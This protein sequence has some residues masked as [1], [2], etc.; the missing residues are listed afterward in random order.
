MTDSTLFRIPPLAAIPGE[1]ASVE[2][3]EAY[4]RQRL[5]DMAWAYFDGGAGDEFTRRNNQLAFQDIALLNRA[6]VDLRGGHTKIELFGHTYEHPIFVA[7]VAYQ[8]LAHPDGELASTV[9]A[10]ALKT[11]MIVSTLASVSLEHIAQHAQYP[12]W[13][14]LYIQ[15]D[16]D[17]TKSLL[18]RAE[19]AG[20][21]AIVVTVD[22]PIN[23]VRNREQRAGFQLPPTIGAENLR[24]M[25]PLPAFAAMPGESSV[26]QSPMVQTAPTW[27]DFKWLAGQTR[28]PV[29]AKGILSAHDAQQAVDAG[30]AGVIVSNHGGRTLDTA[31]PTIQVLPH[32]ARAVGTQV[33]V[34][35]DGGIRRGT[36]VLKALAL[37]AKAVLVGRPVIHGLAAAGAPGVAHVLHILRSE[38]EVAMVLC[39]RPTLA[40]IDAT[41]IWNPHQHQAG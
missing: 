16:R 37:G 2:D 41:A 20:Y 3:Y 13:F 14:Q 8:R 19:Q 40:D 28:L 26:F 18:Q 11:G 30:A 34:L 5:S 9:A 21:R 4:A 24:G 10:S 15:H 38:L 25:S 29:L 36:D 7:P 23:G 35:M 17:F 27:A 12:L 6:M 39:G 31:P 32:I 33:P 1:I 22:A